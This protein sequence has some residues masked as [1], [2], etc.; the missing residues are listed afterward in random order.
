MFLDY[1]YY[2]SNLFKEEKEAVLKK[3]IT[4][5]GNFFYNYIISTSGLE[6]GFNYL[7]ICLI[8]YFKLGYSFIS[9]I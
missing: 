2:S 3:F 1:Y 7:N 4:S 6:E 8:I 5:I 9:F